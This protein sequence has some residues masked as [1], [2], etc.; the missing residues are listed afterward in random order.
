MSQNIFKKIKHYIIKK[1]YSKPLKSQSYY[2]DRLTE[3]NHPRATAKQSTSQS[4]EFFMTGLLV[5]Y[6]YIHL[7]TP[8]KFQ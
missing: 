2:F 8:I 4:M 7:E 5:A 6:I 1:A 3:V